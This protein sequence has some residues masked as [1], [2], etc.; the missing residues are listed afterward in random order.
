MGNNNNKEVKKEEVVISLLKEISSLKEGEKV[1]LGS[2]LKDLTILKGILLTLNPSKGV[3]KVLR[4]LFSP[5]SLPYPKEDS[6]KRDIISFLK[7]KEEAKLF[8]SFSTNTI[9]GIFNIPSN[10][11]SKV[12]T[13]LKELVE[14]GI[15][16]VNSKDTREYY[17]ASI[18]K[19]EEEALREIEGIVLGGIEAFSKDNN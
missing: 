9:R 18:P 14:E 15:L 16:K 10:N 4:D 19:E 8:S 5:S 11:N 3:I 13:P 2:L 17:L 6:F 7:R 1:T 12:Y